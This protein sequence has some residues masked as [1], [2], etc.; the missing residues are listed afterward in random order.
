MKIIV[1]NQIVKF[2]VSDAAKILYHPLISKGDNEISFRW[3]SLLEYLGLGS[4]LSKLFSFDDNPAVFEACIVTLCT[5]QNRDTICE[6]YD[7]LFAEHLNQISALPEIQ[8][9]FLLRALKE[10]RQ[11][12]TPQELKNLLSPVLTAYE[13]ALTENTSH[14]RHD[15]ILYLAWDRM[16]VSMARLFDFQS[17]DPDFIKGIAVLRDCLIESYQHIALQGRTT[18]GIYRMLE[19]FLFY[20]MRQEKLQTL[21]EAEWI[22]LSQSFQVLKGQDELIDFFYIDDAL[23]HKKDLNIQED[24]NCYLS[25]ESLSK[26]NARLAMVHYMLDQLKSE[27]HNWDYV[28]SHKKI[29]YL[30]DSFEAH[31][32]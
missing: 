14:T 4:V 16:C 20:Q 26:V 21:T 30:S 8:P 1:D 13:I 12:N 6:L 23:I 9:S 18:P 29:A 3:P 2:F 28:L 27:V 5:N 22:L 24:T 25:L 10:Q 19:S 32:S 17:D 31:S 15:L 7:R 11:K